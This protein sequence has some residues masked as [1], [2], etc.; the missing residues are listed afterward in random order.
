MSGKECYQENAVSGS[1][2][3]R[4]YIEWL[5]WTAEK[6]HIELPVLKRMICVPH[7]IF[8]VSARYVEH[9]VS[10][11][12]RLI[13]MP[14]FLYQWKNMNRL[15]LLALMHQPRDNEWHFM[16]RHKGRSVGWGFVSEIDPERVGAVSSTV[17]WVW[18]V[19]CHKQKRRTHIEIPVH[20]PLFL[21]TLFFFFFL[22]SF[23]D[24]YQ[25][26]RPQ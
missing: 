18:F 14:L 6:V 23:R 11:K 25:W 4:Y 19:P 10:K 22:I 20:R 9:V 2:K 8:F 5:I 3:E 13:H 21:F 15:I 1:E 12:I 26:T 24:L 7:A 16:P 17:R